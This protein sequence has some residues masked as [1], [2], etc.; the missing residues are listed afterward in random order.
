MNAQH[1]QESKATILIIDDK[2][3]NLR[4]LSVIL[5]EA[6]YTVRQL[7]QPERVV[8]SVLNIPPDII[9]LDILMPEIDGY[10]VCRQL[11]AEK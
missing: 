11:K 10:E 9:L 2:P 4:L 1:N 5:E 6:E 8:S 3:E 7:R